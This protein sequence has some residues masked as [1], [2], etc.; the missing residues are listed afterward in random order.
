MTAVIDGM[1]QRI[2]YL[3]PTPIEVIQA[4]GANVRM[5]QAFGRNLKNII[6]TVHAGA[7]YTLGETAAGVAAFSLIPGAQPMV[8][9]RR[10]RAEYTR[11][12]ESD[13]TATTAVAD[14]DPADIAARFSEGGRADVT[15]GVT[16]TD[17]EDAVVFEGTYE[18]AL[19]KAQA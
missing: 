5:R 3:E 1:L 8:L 14:G 6:G 9:L 7:L 11:R 2:P 16:I 13:I 4:D 19:R 10:A 18:Y 17:A 12:V 15:I